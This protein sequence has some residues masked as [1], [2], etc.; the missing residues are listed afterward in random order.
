MKSNSV[1]SPNKKEKKTT[2]HFFKALTAQRH[3]YERLQGKSHP[4]EQAQSPLS[5]TSRGRFARQRLSGE[6]SAS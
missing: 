2:F 3:Q 6:K 5:E 4:V 1:L